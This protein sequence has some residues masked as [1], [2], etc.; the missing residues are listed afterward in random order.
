MQVK[1]NETVCH[2]HHFEPINISA[3]RQPTWCQVSDTLASC[4]AKSCRR[5]SSGRSETLWIGSS[6][7]IRKW[8]YVSLK[9][10]IASVCMYPASVS[11]IC[12]HTAYTVRALSVILWEAS[13]CDC[14]FTSTSGQIHIFLLRSVSVFCKINISI[15]DLSKQCQSASPVKFC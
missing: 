3:S 2:I 1:Q 5:N 4:F 7:S 15:G 14:W 9:G 10:A 11:Y 12:I 13:R 8:I 6:L